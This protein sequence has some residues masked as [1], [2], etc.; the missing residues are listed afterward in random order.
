MSMIKRFIWFVWSHFRWESSA[1]H[2]IQTLQRKETEEMRVLRLLCLQNYTLF[3]C[4]IK[5]FEKNQIQSLEF[6]E[7][8]CILLHQMFI[9][10]LIQFSLDFLQ[11]QKSH[12]KQLVKHILLTFC[13]WNLKFSFFFYQLVWNFRYWLIVLDRWCKCHFK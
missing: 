12:G 8:R 7:Y 13:Y 6:I 4:W 2:I 11:L 10:S 1:Q 5:Y 9:A 3:I